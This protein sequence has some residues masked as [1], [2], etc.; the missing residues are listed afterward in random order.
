MR[1]ISRLSNFDID[2]EN[3][4]WELEDLIDRFEEGEEPQYCYGTLKERV[5]VNID[6]AIDD[7]Q[8]ELPEDC[9]F[10]NTKELI[11]FVEKWNQKNGQDVYYCNNK[12]VILIS[13]EDNE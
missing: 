10:D 7:A 4:Y 5:E 2:E 8:E 9:Y 3:Y 13:E 1:K 11:D 6:C 12:I